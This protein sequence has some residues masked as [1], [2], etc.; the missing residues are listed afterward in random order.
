MEATIAKA[1]LVYGPLGLI[2][3]ISL[4]VTWRLY[5]DITAERDRHVKEMNASRD[6]HAQEMRNLEERYITKAETWMEKNHELAQ[7]INQV[8]ASISKRFER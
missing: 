2:C 7:S 1:F 3:L 6:Q 8:L 4:L 5:R